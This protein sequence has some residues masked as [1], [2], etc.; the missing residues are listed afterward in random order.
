MRKTTAYTP[1]QATEADGC[2]RSAGS[3]AARRVVDRSARGGAHVKHRRVSRRGEGCDS[4]A[5]G[6]V[7]WRRAANDRAFR[8]W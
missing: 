6:E 4:D 5:A 1:E 8:S 3:D 2:F 7:N